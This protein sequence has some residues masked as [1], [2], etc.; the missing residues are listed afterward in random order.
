MGLWSVTG[1]YVKFNYKIYIKFE[2]FFAAFTALAAQDLRNFFS[3]SQKPWAIE[4]L[5]GICVWLEYLKNIFPT[6]IIVDTTKLTLRAIDEMDLAK[7]RRTK[8]TFD[9]KNTSSDV[10]SVLH[11]HQNHLVKCLKIFCCS[12]RSNKGITWCLWIFN[13]VSTLCTSSC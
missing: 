1:T 5:P 3:V 13:Y 2:L 9:R 12:S 10:C 4:M 6:I 8:L 7:F 11:N